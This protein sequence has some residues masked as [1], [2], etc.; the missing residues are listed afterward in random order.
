MKQELIEAVNEFTEKNLE[1]KGKYTY[2]DMQDAFIL[3]WNNGQKRQDELTW[4]DIRQI[5]K[6]ADM[7][8]V[9]DIHINGRGQFP[10]EQRYYEEVLNVFNE[11][12]EK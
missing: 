6:I 8:L 12:K 11:Q 2:H 4:E 7:L 1:K 5:V 3:G 10:E 9:D